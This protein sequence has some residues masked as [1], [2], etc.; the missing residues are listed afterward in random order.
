MMGQPR[1]GAIAL[2]ALAAA[3][4][5]APASA[6]PPFVTDDPEPTEPGHWEIYAFAAG[7]ESRLETE[8]EA[9]LDINFGAAPDLQL[10]AVVPVGIEDDGRTRAGFGD[11]ELAAKYRFLH[12]RQGSLMP[13]ISFFPAVSLP[14]A[15]RGFGTGRVQLFLPLWAQKDFGPWSLFGGGG[16]RINPGRGNRDYWVMGIAA[17]RQLTPRFSLGAELFHETP[18]EVG[19]RAAAGI[20]VGATYRLGG[21]YSLL[22]SFGPGLQNRREEGRYTFYAALKLDL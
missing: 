3:L 14:T 13:D 10:T 22:V 9:G 16:Y 1:I 8:G 21:P 18:E 5:A 17:S 4:G 15:R 20:N 12:Q 7:T 2:S 11:V 19:G 6:G